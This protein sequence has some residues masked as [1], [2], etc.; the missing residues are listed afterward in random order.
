[1]CKRC[2]TLGL[3]HYG[4]LLTVGADPTAILAGARGGSLPENPLRCPME[5][6]GPHTTTKPVSSYFLSQ[7]PRHSQAHGWALPAAPRPDLSCWPCGAARKLTGGPFRVGMAYG[8]RATCRLRAWDSSKV[9]LP[10]TW[11]PSV[12]CLPLTGCS[13]PMPQG[14][15]PVSTQTNGHLRGLWSPRAIRYS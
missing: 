13:G 2:H 15:P 7:V 9:P 1:M 14:R 3:S 11:L 8:Q 12:S 10:D 5:S 4:P 6:P